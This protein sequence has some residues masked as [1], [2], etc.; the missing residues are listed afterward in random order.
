MAGKIFFRERLKVKEDEKKP[1]FILVAVAGVDLRIF[2]KHLRKSE[3]EHIASE[4]G[5]ELI[6]LRQGEKKDEE[7]EV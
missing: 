5:A 6:Q 7:V 1:R 3:L 2:A 4:L